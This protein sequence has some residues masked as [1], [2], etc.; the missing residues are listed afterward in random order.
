MEHHKHLHEMLV[1]EAIKQNDHEFAACRK[2]VQ[3]KLVKMECENHCICSSTC[4]R[5]S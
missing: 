1:L 3:K 2:T 5:C 4:H